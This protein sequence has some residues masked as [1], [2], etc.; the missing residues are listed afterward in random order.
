MISL[1]FD[2]DHMNEA[3]M[4]EFLAEVTWPGG[5]TFFC[6]QPYECLD[7]DCFEVAPHPFLTGDRNWLVELRAKRI[8]F[9]NAVGWRA[10][11]CVFSHTLAEWISCNGYVYASTHDSFGLRG[12]RPHRHLWGMWHVPIYYMDNLDFS[13]HRFCP[14]RKEKPFDRCLI[15]TACRP[16]GLYVFDFHPIH[17]LLNT[18]D[19]E[20]YMARRDEFLAGEQAA[21]LRYDGYG[22]RSFFDELVCAMRTAACDS[23]PIIEALGAFV[24]EEIKPRDISMSSYKFDEARLGL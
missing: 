14:E 13:R 9:P 11:S 12:I 23:S 10:H 8:E 17:L 22:A 5:A 20:W 4:S 3:R 18:P 24:G 2:T 6:T 1:S 16:D 19:P 21:M 7:R 15:E